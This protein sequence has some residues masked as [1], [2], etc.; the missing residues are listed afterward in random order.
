MAET[1]YGD[2]G[3]SG[4]S[5]YTDAIEES[6]GVFDATGE[7]RR[8]LETS[9]RLDTN[10]QY[11]PGQGVTPFLFNVV[12]LN[13]LNQK[14]Q[15]DTGGVCGYSAE[16]YDSIREKVMMEAHIRFT[17]HPGPKLEH[18]R[19]SWFVTSRWRFLYGNGNEI[20]MD[21]VTVLPTLT[22]LRK[23]MIAIGCG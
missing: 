19:A 6:L 3:S 7:E 2:G 13:A 15:R 16:C 23:D 17:I 5:R 10:I 1:Y 12:A 14:A 9:E 4:F 8:W 18:H 21:F 20:S 11:H 22:L